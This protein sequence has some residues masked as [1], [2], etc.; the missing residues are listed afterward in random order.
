LDRIAGKAWYGSPGSQ[1]WRWEARPDVVRPVTKLIAIYDDK[2][3]P[4][5]VAIPAQIGRA[6]D[7]AGSK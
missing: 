2:A 7:N 5:F 4:E 3:D 1:G 6:Q